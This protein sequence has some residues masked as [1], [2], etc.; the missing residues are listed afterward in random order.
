MKI[1]QLHTLTASNIAF[2]INILVIY[3]I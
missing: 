2:R 1:R 3:V